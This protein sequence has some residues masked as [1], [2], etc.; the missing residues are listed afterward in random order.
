MMRGLQHTLKEALI[1][2]D[3]LPDVIWIHSERSFNNLA[4]AQ[5]IAE[6]QEEGLCSSV[7]L[8]ITEEDEPSASEEKER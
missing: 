2:R 8:A 5:Q 1:A 4:F 6:L 7:H 3:E